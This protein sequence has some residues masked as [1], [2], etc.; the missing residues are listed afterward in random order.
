MQ[1]TRIESIKSQGSNLKHLKRD[2]NLFVKCPPDGFS[3][4][5]CPICYDIF[6]VPFTSSCSHTFC[7]TCIKECLKFNKQCPI[8][9]VSLTTKKLFYN[10]PL[11]EII[12]YLNYAEIGKEV[13]DM[14]LKKFTSWK[15]P[16]AQEKKVENRFKIETDQKHRLFHKS[17]YRIVKKARKTICTDKKEA[18]PFQVFGLPANSEINDCP[19]EE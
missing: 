3:D 9:R 18:P 2:N 7:S 8:C 6:T 19:M 14:E 13:S 15:D 17:Q 1:P 11:Q 10:R 4:L 5:I 16:F 12:N